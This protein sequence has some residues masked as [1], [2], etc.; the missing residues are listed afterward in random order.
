MKNKAATIPLSD[1]FVVAVLN[2]DRVGESP[3]DIYRYPARFSPRFVREAIRCFT[4]RG[5][6]VVDPFCGGGTSVVEAIALGRRAA[7]MD[8]NSL[9]TFLTRAKTTPLSIHDVRDIRAWAARL[10]SFGSK[11]AG[12]ATLEQFT[13]RSRRHVPSHVSAFFDRVLARLDS[14][15]KG[16][17]QNFVRLVLLSVGQWALDCKAR[18]FSKNIATASRIFFGASADSGSMPRFRHSA[19]NRA[20]QQFTIFSTRAASGNAC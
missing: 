19:I 15:P 11:T 2:Q 12:E 1:A 6:L 16:R 4:D 20:S 13:E 8:I 14:V 5:D 3:H 9:A 17:Q 18:R 7:G 10:R